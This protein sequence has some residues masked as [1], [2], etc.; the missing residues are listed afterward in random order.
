[1]TG[2]F[3]AAAPMDVPSRGGRKEFG[4][5][6]RENCRKN[7]RLAADEVA[8]RDELAGGD[9]TRVFGRPSRSF[10]SSAD[11]LDRKDEATSVSQS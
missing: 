8:E 7:S 5:S 4:S 6:G 1:M 10:T 9:G 3:S 11:A 2:R